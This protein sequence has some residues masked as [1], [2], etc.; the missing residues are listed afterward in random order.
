[1]VAPGQ[2]T[3]QNSAVRTQRQHYRHMV[4]PLAYVRVDHAN[5]GILRDLS[6][7]G[8]GVQAVAPLHT[9]QVVHLRFDLLRPRLRIETTGQVIWADRSG[10][11]GIRFLDLGAETQRDLKDWLFVTLL[12]AASELSMC[13]SPMFKNREEEDEFDGLIMSS[14][15][16][17]AIR[18]TPSEAPVRSIASQLPL[19]EEPQDAEMPVRLSWWPVDISPTVLARFVDGLI[20]VSAVLLFSIV[21][22]ATTGTFPSWLAAFAIVAGVACTFGY[23]YRYLFDTFSLDDPVTFP[24][25]QLAEDEDPRPWLGGATPSGV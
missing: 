25:E 17:P 22:V 4:S 8:L 6:E 20:I 10:Q 23:I 14:P 13:R 24:P 2:G 3:C 7:S 12:T 5:G 11:A 15:P 9:D 21:F 18:L 19:I 16:V 1:M